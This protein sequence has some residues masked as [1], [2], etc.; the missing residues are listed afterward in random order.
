MF[1]CLSS[2]GILFHYHTFFSLHYFLLPFTS[3]TSVLLIFFLILFLFPSFRSL[4][5]LPFPFPSFPPILFPFHLFPLIFPPLSSIF[6]NFF[7]FYKSL[8][9][10]THAHHSISSPFS[11]LFIL[12]CSF[13]SPSI[14]YSH[15]PLHPSSSLTHAPHPSSSLAHFFHTRHVP[16]ISPRGWRILCIRGW[17]RSRERRAGRRYRRATGF[18]P[19]CLASSTR[20]LGRGRWCYRPRVRSCPAVFAPW[21]SPTEKGTK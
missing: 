1:R 18:P 19:R 20:V 3:F 17:R 13:H 7:L 11:V 15:V 14:P 10:I 5:F 8:L 2:F 21:K 16:G 9:S 12:L 6:V 4:H